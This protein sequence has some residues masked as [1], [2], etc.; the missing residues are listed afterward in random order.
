VDTNAPTSALYYIVTAYDVHENQSVPSNE[1][2][3]GALTAVG[4]TAPV[5][6]TVLDNAPNPFSAQTTLR[7]GLPKTSDVEI[8][9]FDVAGRR[10]RHQRLAAVPAGWRDLSFEARDTA[11]HELSSGVYFYRVKAVGTT[12]T[13]KMAIAR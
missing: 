11:G 13:R 12:I 7:I 4:R 10:V 5:T 9:V 2:S 8:D 1:A 6:L 3:V